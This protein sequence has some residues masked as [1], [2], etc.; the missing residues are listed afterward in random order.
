M[1]R[2][3]IVISWTPDYVQRLAW[4]QARHLI[5]LGYKVTILDLTPFVSAIF[6][7]LHKKYHL[8]FPRLWFSMKSLLGLS[9][10]S[11]YRSIEPF[12]SEVNENTFSYIRCFKS[13]PWSKK[14]SN[15]V[16]IEPIS[17][18][19]GALYLDA[20]GETFDNCPSGEKKLLQK[21]CQ[22]L[23]HDCSLIV[24]KHLESHEWYIYN[25]RF[26]V[27]SILVRLL[28]LSKQKYQLFEAG[29][30]PSSIALYSISPHSIVENRER[31][32]QIWNEASPSIRIRESEIFMESR[33]SRHQ[34]QNGFWNAF[35]SNGYTRPLPKNKSLISFFL[36]TEGEISSLATSE[37]M[38]M[39]TDQ[40]ESLMWLSQ[41]MD[42]KKHHLV[43]RGHPSH[44]KSANRNPFLNSK[45]LKHLREGTFTYIRANDR[46]DSIE[47]IRRSH[48]VCVYDSSLGM[49]TIFLGKPLLI[50]G[51]PFFSSIL[52]RKVDFKNTI[53]LDNVSSW[54]YDPKAVLP[55]AFYLLNNGRSL[56]I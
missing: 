44:S 23:T 13:Y 28:K 55:W 30:R 56:E 2:K 26:P 15:S 37:K 33:T 22:R 10:S 45:A 18:D 24:D 27:D 19:L 43:I 11:Q 35:Q 47:L 21:L 4:D 12:C 5:L 1:Q 36:S 53:D 14:K 17:Y 29:S 49:E 6:A 31:A 40:W 50:F 39:F 8:L 3:I 52:E 7:I 51:M 20:R 54:I 16:E 41:Q 34:S 32:L 46:D 48:L 38:T 9:P 25:G 42:P